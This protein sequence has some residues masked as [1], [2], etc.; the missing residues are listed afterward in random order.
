MSKTCIRALVGYGPN[1]LKIASKPSHS[2][3]ETDQ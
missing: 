2:N 1:I 3:Y